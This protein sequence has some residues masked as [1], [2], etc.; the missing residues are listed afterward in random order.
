MRFIN[1]PG[2]AIDDDDLRF[3]GETLQE[4]CC[5]GKERATDDSDRLRMRHFGQQPAKRAFV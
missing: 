2:I 1:V 5:A 4:Q 3:G